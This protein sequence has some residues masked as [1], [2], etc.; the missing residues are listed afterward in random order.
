MADILNRD[1]S[2]PKAYVLNDYPLSTDRKPEDKVSEKIL[3]D[4]FSDDAK[5]ILYTGNFHKYQGID[6]LLDSVAELKQKLSPE[7]KFKL[8]LVGG[9]AGDKKNLDFYQET[10][11]KL[12]LSA[13]VVFCGE[14]PLETMPVFMSNADVLVSS[15]SQ[16]NN[17]PLKIYNYLVSGT[18]LVATN[19]NSHTQI[20]NN[21][22][23]ILADPEPKSFADALKYA[24]FEIPEN[25]KEQI[26]S[27]TQA[28]H[29]EKE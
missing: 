5:V 20:L 29:P 6:L 8:L 1:F 11:R 17:V 22:N 27:Q 16:G 26:I 9:L 7:Q 3:S 28:I 4:Y 15:R 19:I 14:Y 25:K 24:L 12:N 21:A 13:S 2:K 10:V 18:L 23:S